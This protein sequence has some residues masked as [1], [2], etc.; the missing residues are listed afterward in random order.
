MNFGFLVVF[1]FFKLHRS[2][3]NLSL[4]KFKR[5]NYLLMFFFK[6][7]TSFKNCYIILIY[8]INDIFSLGYFFYFYIFFKY[9]SEF[10]IY[11]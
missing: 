4:D 6:I 3:F 7:V 1:L 11:S 8:I 10:R 5:K 2:S 9:I